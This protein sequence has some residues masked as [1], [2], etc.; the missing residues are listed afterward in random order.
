MAAHDTTP[1]PMVSLSSLAKTN[2]AAIAAIREAVANKAEASQLRR[3]LEIAAADLARAHS[4]TLMVIRARTLAE[5]HEIADADVV[6]LAVAHRIALDALERIGQPAPARPEVTP[7]T[8]SGV[9]SLAAERAR[10]AGRCA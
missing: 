3:A 9:T 4:A 1:E 8:Q 2:Q 7:G 10:R 5:A 6:E